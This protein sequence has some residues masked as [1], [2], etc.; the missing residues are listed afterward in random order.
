MYTYSSI[1]R[2]FAGTGLLI[3]GLQKSPKIVCFGYKVLAVLTVRGSS[4]ES[5]SGYSD[6]S[7]NIVI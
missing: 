3:S 7:R 2:L 5:F 4:Y 6:S 1:L